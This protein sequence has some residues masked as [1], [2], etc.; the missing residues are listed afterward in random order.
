MNKFLLGRELKRLVLVLIGSVLMALNINIF[1]R[2]GNLFP[3]GFSGVTLLL[4]NVFLKF[5]GIKIPYSLVVY[6]FNVFPVIIGFKY[7]GKKFTIYSVVMIVVSGFL[8]DV[9]SAIPALRLTEDVLLC[10]IFGGILNSVAVACCLFADSSSGGTDFIAIYVAEKTGKS[11]WNYILI[12]N[13]CILFVAGLLFGWDKA[14]YSIVFQYA[15]TQALNFLYKRYEK[16]TLLIITD[17]DSEIYEAIKRLTNHGATVFEGKGEFSQKNHKML[18][19]VVSSDESGK[20]EKEIR[21][22]DPDAFINVLKSKE[23][24]GKFFKRVTD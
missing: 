8:T 10:C 17:K 11:A 18:Y 21:K 16:T 1:V 13:C 19:T 23:I 12:G 6:L 5:L 2:S 9:F 3:G 24:I 14:L 15:S 22:I 20:L 4:Q 7:I